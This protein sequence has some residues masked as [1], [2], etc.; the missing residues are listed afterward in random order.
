[1]ANYKRVCTFLK[2]IILIQQLVI[3]GGKYVCVEIALCERDTT[4]L[5]QIFVEKWVNE[6]DE[7]MRKLVGA[8]LSVQ[9]QRRLKTNINKKRKKI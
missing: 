2:F 5:K 4:D 9:I 8:N 6:C 3:L 1:M 7:R